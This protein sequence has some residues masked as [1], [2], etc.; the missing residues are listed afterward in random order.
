MAEHIKTQKHVY[1]QGHLR[2]MKTV[3]GFPTWIN[4][5]FFNAT[6]YVT[7]QMCVYVG[8]LMENDV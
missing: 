2:F 6:H 3:I 5:H 1:S 4:R 8:V 7:W